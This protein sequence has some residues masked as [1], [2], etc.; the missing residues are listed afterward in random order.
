MS[1]TPQGVSGTSQTGGTL[2]WSGFPHTP[3]PGRIF[4]LGR[5]SGQTLRHLSL[6]GLSNS[7]A[8]FSILQI[9]TDYPRG[10]L[11][12]A[13]AL[14]NPLFHL[15]LSANTFMY[16]AGILAL[17]FEPGLIS[18]LPGED[19]YIIVYDWKSNGSYDYLTWSLNMLWEPLREE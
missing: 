1:L 15:Y 6:T 17:N 11:D 13:N 5:W 12:P 3:A 19:L 18:V 8:I 4:H 9:A 16:G 14:P 2:N 10:G 7:G